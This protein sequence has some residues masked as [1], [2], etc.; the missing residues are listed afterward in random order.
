[1]KRNKFNIE[2]IYDGEIYKKFL[3]N[4]GL[5][6]EYYLFNVFFTMNIDG[7]FIFKSL[8][9]FIWLVYFMINELFKKERKLIENMMLCGL[10][11]GEIKFFM[12]VFGKSLY[13][14]LKI[15]EILGI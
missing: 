15:L 11:F 8:K 6:S 4:N 10:W 5:L 14:V 3:I 12:F 9:F 2:D 1:M 13:E 7:V